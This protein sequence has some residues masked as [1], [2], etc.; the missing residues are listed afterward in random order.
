M[1]IWAMW[2]TFCGDARVAARTLV[3]S[4]GFV[5]VVVISLSLGI[6]ANS[7]IISILNAILYRPLPYPQADRPTNLRAGGVLFGDDRSG[8]VLFAGEEGDQGRSA[9]SVAVEQ[10]RRRQRICRLAMGG[11]PRP[12]SGSH[13]FN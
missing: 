6:A 10:K 12:G 8:G 9:G 11:K 13:V 5:G 2:E 1:K 4:P 7:T 3:K